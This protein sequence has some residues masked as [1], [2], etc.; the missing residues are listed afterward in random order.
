MMI[1]RNRDKE[2]LARLRSYRDPDDD[3]PEEPD[4]H[5]DDVKWFGIWMSERNIMRIGFGNGALIILAY[6]VKSQFGDQIPWLPKSAWFDWAFVGVVMVMGFLSFTMFHTAGQKY[7]GQ[8]REIDERVAR[9]DKATDEEVEKI[10]NESEKRINRRLWK[11][12]L[13]FALLAVPLW[14]V[15]GTDAIFPWG[16]IIFFTLAVVLIFAVAY[17]WEYHRQAL[18]DKLLRLLL[19]S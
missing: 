18:V 9:R 14:L 1:N 16:N 17:V 12:F 11:R 3:Y 15:I 10:V 2:E 6:F 4:P 7:R 5:K 19:G 8:I 13:F